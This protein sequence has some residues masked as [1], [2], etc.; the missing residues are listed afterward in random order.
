MNTA[1]ALMTGVTAAWVVAM[2]LISIFRPAPSV[3]VKSTPGV[4]YG[5]AFTNSQ[6]KPVKLIFYPGKQEIVVPA[7]DTIYFAPD[8]LGKQP[9]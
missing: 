6:D 7:H 4:L 2:V 3:T 9:R 8:D 1:D 5:G